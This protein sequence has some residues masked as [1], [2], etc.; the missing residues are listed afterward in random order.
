MLKNYHNHRTQF[1]HPLEVGYFMLI[2]T[3]APNFSLTFQSMK[4]AVTK[5]LL[6]TQKTICC[7]CCKLPVVAA[8]EG[9]AVV[10][11]EGT[12]YAIATCLIIVVTA[13][14]HAVVAVAICFDIVVITSVHAVVAVAT[15]FDIVVITSVHVVVAVATCFDI[16]VITSVH[17]VVAKVGACLVAAATRLLIAVTA[18]APAT[19]AMS[20]VAKEE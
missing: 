8:M 14:V 11:N 16:V 10:A 12:T 5:K 4:R 17:A 9:I 1:L 13:R 18:C 20:S 15:C 6:T 3:L 7:L 2:Y 19:I